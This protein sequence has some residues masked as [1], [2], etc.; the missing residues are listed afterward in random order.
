MAIH[1]PDGLRWCM[2][3]QSARSRAVALLYLALLS[4]SPGDA[5]EP[6][7]NAT[8]RPYLDAHPATCVALHKGQICYQW[9]D[10]RWR[11]LSPGHYCLYLGDTRNALLCWSNEESG[12]FRH[13]YTSATSERYILRKQPAPASLSTDDVQ[14]AESVADTANTTLELEFTV[15]TAWVYRTGRR[16]SS[17]W[18]LF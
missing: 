18:R 2:A 13:R 17:G 7:N 1:V 12:S 10:I 5:A 9:L 3:V 6:S 4:A 15:T 14:H 8:P 16:S 11:D